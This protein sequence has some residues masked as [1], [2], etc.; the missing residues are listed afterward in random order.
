MHNK[1]AIICTIRNN[2]PP[3]DKIPQNEVFQPY[4]K[5]RRPLQNYFKSF[6][7]ED[8]YTSDLGLICASKDRSNTD[9]S[10][11]QPP[12]KNPLRVFSKTPCTRWRSKP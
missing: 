2:R 1:W 8:D 3:M 11:I 4:I 9:L 6:A 7:T 10:T 12:M 5:A